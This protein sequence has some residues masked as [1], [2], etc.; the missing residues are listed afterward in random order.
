MGYNHNWRRSL[1]SRNSL[2][3]ASKRR[4]RTLLLKKYDFGKGT[5]SI[6][7]KLIHGGV[8]YLSKGDITLVFESLKK[9]EF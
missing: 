1:W 6:S 9:D 3:I 2:L 7:T 4:Y 8:K 5:S